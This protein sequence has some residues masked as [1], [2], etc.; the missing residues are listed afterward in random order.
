MEDVLNAT[1]A[2]GNFFN[3]KNHFIKVLSLVPAPIWLLHQLWLF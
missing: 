1:L 3:I 2:G